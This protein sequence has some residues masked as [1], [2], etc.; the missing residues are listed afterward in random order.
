MPTHTVTASKNINILAY[1]GSITYSSNNTGIPEGGTVTASVGS[2]QITEDGK[3]R[4]APPVNPNMAA[5][6]T[7]TYSHLVNENTNGGNN[8]QQSF[9]EV[10]N[11]VTTTIGNLYN[12]S[13]IHFSTINHFRVTGRIRY[14]T[15]GWFGSWNNVPANADLTISTNNATATMLS[16]ARYELITNGAPLDSQNITIR[17]ARSGT[18]YSATKTIGTLRTNQSF[19]LRN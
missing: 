10:Y 5:P 18:T 3:Y 4:Y 11:S 9:H 6:V 14:L 15:S 16:T 7:L 12:S 1:K 17:Y 8:I 2:M 19:D 13:A